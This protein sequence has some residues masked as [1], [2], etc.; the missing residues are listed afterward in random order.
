MYLS[1]PLGEGELGLPSESSIGLGWVL[2]IQTWVFKNHCQV[3]LK[4]SRVENPKHF[5]WFAHE[6]NLVQGDVIA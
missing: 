2:G 3:K 5:S 4:D 6:G 1:N